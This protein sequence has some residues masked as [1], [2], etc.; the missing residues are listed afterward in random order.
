MH[1]NM[2]AGLHSETS[3]FQK[4]IYHE[5]VPQTAAELVVPNSKNNTGVHRG[6]VGGPPVFVRIIDN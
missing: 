1:V 4:N 3:P 6:A 2:R 5:L